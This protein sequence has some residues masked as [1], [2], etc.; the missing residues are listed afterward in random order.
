MRAAHAKSQQEIQFA[1][2]KIYELLVSALAKKE[3]IA[4]LGEGNIHF[5]VQALLSNLR[6]VTFCLTLVI[7]HKNIKSITISVSVLAKL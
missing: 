5:H 3:D 2:H 4:G 6:L 7:L 1:V